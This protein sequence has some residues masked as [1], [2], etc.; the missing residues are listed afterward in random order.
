MNKDRCPKL[1]IAIVFIIGGDGG[2]GVESSLTNDKVKKLLS[3]KGCQCVCMQPELGWK[4]NNHGGAGPQ[5]KAI[6]ALI[7][8]TELQN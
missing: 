7:D 6:L 8:I 5:I 3:L 4:T 2:V 1:L